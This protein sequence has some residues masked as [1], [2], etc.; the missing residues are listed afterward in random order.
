M[1]ETIRIGAVSYLNSKP[2]VHELECL[3]RR[4]S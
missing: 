2:L 3:P 4:P 1:M